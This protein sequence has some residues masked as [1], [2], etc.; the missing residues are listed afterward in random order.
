MESSGERD[1]DAL[2]QVMA[3][4]PQSDELSSPSPSPSPDT[5][6]NPYQV[7]A[8]S[9]QFDEADVAR[10]Q[11]QRATSRASARGGLLRGLLRR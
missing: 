2:F 6:P 5:N 4:S 11:R 3:N 7:I 8:T 10:L 9:L 1:T